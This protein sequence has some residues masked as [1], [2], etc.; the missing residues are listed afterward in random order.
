M[1]DPVKAPHPQLI[2]LAAPEWEDYELLDSGNGAKLER[3]GE[4]FLQVL[5]DASNGGG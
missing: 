3:Y 4:A 2:L 5:N 1:S